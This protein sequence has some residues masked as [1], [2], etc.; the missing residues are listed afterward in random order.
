MSCLCLVGWLS[1]HVRVCFWSQ[2]RPQPK[3]V[4]KSLCPVLSA[5]TTS[6][7]AVLVSL[8][9]KGDLNIA[10]LKIPTVLPYIQAEQWHIMRKTLHTGL[11]QIYPLF[12][13]AIL[14][15]TVVPT[16]HTSSEKIMLQLVWDKACLPSLHFCPNF[17]IA[18]LNGCFLQLRVQTM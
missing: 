13:W 5:Q 2:N 15:H 9:T 10:K 1:H 3:W 18:L 14:L 11:S 7:S 6:S 12:A 16:T 8:S 4:F 17:G